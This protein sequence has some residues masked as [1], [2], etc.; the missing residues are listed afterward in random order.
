MI[1]ATN[2][3]SCAACCQLRQRARQYK[4]EQLGQTSITLTFTPTQLETL[5]HM[6]G[7]YVPLDRDEA[8]AQIREM[9]EQAMEGL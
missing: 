4:A 7:R 8:V 9:V 1:K 6:A 5:R 3:C 2:G